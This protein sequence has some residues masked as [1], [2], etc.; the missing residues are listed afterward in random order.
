MNGYFEEINGN[1]YL[2]MIPT[3]ESKEKSKK[4]EE[5]W[6]EIRDL[7]RSI[8]KNSDNYDE[9]H[10]KIKFNSD[11]VLLL[12]KTIKIPTV[13]IFVRAAFYKNNKYYPKVLLDEC[14]YKI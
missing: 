10:M 4:Y 3:N 2:T 13:T 12:S 6:I 11:N 9:K 1:R 14:L 8:T 5:L 7:L